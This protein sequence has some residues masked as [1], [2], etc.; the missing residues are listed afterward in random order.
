[1]DDLLSLQRMARA[2]GV[3]RVWLRDQAAGGNVPVLRAGKRLLFS[4]AATV[5]AVAAMAGK[6]GA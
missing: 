3:T 2:L 4:R 1:M 5:A 6:G